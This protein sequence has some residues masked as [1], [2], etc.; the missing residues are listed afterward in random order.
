MD[1]SAIKRN[2]ESGA[3]RTTSEVQ[4]DFMLM[5]TNAIMYNNSRHD[6]HQMAEQM[7]D[8]VLSHI[9]VSYCY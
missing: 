6:V 4:R 7:Y 3:L 2:I 8:D 5:F 1:L 9:E